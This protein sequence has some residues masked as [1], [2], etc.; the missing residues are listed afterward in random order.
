MLKIFTFLCLVINIFSIN[1]NDTFDCSKHIKKCF[2]ATDEMYNVSANGIHINTQLSDGIKCNMNYTLCMCT[3]CRYNHVCVY[4]DYF[5]SEILYA[6]NVNMTMTNIIESIF[7]QTK[8][9]LSQYPYYYKFVCSISYKSCVMNLYFHV[10]KL[11]MLFICLLCVITF[12]FFLCCLCFSTIKH[13]IIV[14]NEIAKD[15]YTSIAKSIDVEM[16]V[17]RASILDRLC[18]QLKK[19]IASEYMFFVVLCVIGCATLFVYIFMNFIVYK[20]YVNIY[21]TLLENKY[22]MCTR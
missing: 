17:M 13:K 9:A 7:K 20:L 11:L 4:S 15:G 8:N 10:I 3:R 21:K 6:Q 12:F 1:I 22:D 2:I 14:K 19:G 16:S 18:V 5:C